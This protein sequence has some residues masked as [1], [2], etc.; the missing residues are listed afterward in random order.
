MSAFVLGLRLGQDVQ[1]YLQLGII[2]FRWKFLKGLL[3]WSSKNRIPKIEFLK[4][5]SKNRI[6]KIDFEKF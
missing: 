2:I 6:L 1:P 5:T 3:N 4:S